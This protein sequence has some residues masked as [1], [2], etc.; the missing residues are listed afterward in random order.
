M[1]DEPKIKMTDQQYQI[2]QELLVNLAQQVQLLDLY[3]FL[4]RISEADSWGPIL[5]PTLY[6]ASMKNLQDI[7]NLAD[8]ALHFQN[9]VRKIAER[10]K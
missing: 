2:T 4:S 8:G 9:V 7:K 10:G 5:D 1:S 6:R 3:G